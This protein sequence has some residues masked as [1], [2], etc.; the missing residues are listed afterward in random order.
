[1]TFIKKVEDII[2]KLESFR[3]KI[4]AQIALESVNRSLKV[5]AIQPCP[6]NIQLSSSSSTAATKPVPFFAAA[7]SN[8]TAAHQASSYYNNQRTAVG[9]S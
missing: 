8:L 6:T 1:M 3:C 7:T 4:L 5:D 2:I 9:R